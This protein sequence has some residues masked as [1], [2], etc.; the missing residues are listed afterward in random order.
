MKN[1]TILVAM[2]AMFGFVFAGCGEE[3]TETETPAVEGEDTADEAVEEATEE[4]EEATEEATEE[5]EEA[6]AEADGV[7]GRAQTCCQALVDATNAVA[8]GSAN[9]EQ[10]CGTISSVAGTPGAD[11]ACQT[12]IDGYRQSLEAMSAEVPEACGAAAAE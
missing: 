2:L 4:V 9:A 11:A 12:M 8:A 6:T 5:A 7:C 10:M 3:T 1:W